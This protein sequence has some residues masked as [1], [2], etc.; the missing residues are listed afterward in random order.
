MGT[1][2]RPV[3]T[4]SPASCQPGT[5]T[6]PAWSRAPPKPPR[7]LVRSVKPACARSSQARAERPPLWQP[8]RS[9][10]VRGMV[11]P[12][13][14]T[15]SAFGIGWRVAG[16]KNTTGTLRAPAGW[17]ASNSASVRTSRYTAAGSARR[18][19]YA[20]GGVV[21]RM[22]MPGG[23][24][25]VRPP[26]LYAAHAHHRDLRGCGRVRRRR[27]AGR[28]PLA[29]TV[30]A[31]APRLGPRARGALPRA[32][33][34][35]DPASAPGRAGARRRRGQPGGARPPPWP[36]GRPR[37][38]AR[39][40]G[41]RSRRRSPGDD[42]PL[43]RRTRLHAPRLGRPP[44]QPVPAPRPEGT[45]Q[46]LGLLV[47]V[48]HGPAGLAGTLRG[49]R[50]PELQRRHGR[51]GCGRR[52]GRPPVDRGGEADAPEPHR[53]APRRR[54]ALRLGERSLERV[55]RRGGS[56]RAPERP[57]LRGRILP[58]DDGAGL[59][60][61]SD[62][63]GVR[64]HP[65]PLP[66]GRAR[67]GRQ[68]AREPLDARARAGARADGG[69]EP[70]SCARRGLL[71]AR[72][73]PPRAGKGGG[74]TAR[75]RRCET[76]PAREL[77]LQAAGLAPRGAGEVRRPRVL[78]RGEGAGRPAVLPAPGAVGATRR[79]SR[80]RRRA[81]RRGR[82]SRARAARAPFRL[83]A[84]AT[85]RTGRRTPRTHQPR[86]AAGAARAW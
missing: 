80:P 83:G 50:A 42:P 22:S 2:Y 16:S 7:T 76:A 44:P 74:G 51:H 70:G 38:R 39:R 6:R 52:A 17:P 24:A 71:P 5:T 78:G 66:G 19:S 58:R 20:S 1:S 12:T 49:A 56:H 25:E 29:R 13:F 84:H 57:G 73:V 63:E 43:A 14:A 68:R 3:S 79:G 40:L 62:D 30:R 53:H 64:A 36:G 26:A 9:F 8:T 59:R 33:L 10:A 54:R 21:S 47:R 45:P 41:V 60:L 23:L 75:V 65:R 31:R 69:A 77:E 34:R 15:K 46:L 82:C 86:S 81:V 61:Q 55:D 28:G 85:R 67:L 35:A 32:A 11:R 48:P 18:V 72:Y 37:R 27:G 4:G